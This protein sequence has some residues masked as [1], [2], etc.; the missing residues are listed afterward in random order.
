MKK[1]LAA[2]IAAALVAVALFCGCAP[3]D[4]R[5][6]R[7]GKDGQDVSIR[8]IYEEAKAIPGNEELTFE[9]FLKQY[10]SYDG[11]ALE[12]AASLKAAVNNSLMCGVTVLTRFPYSGKSSFVLPSARSYLVY[13]G[14]G[15]IID[16]DKE[17]G[18]AYVVTNCHVVYD[19]TSLTPYSEDIRLYLYGQDERDVNYIIDSSY[20]ISGDENYKISAE[21]AG[22]SRDYDLALLKISDSE[23]LKRSDARAAVFSDDVDAH[24]GETAYTIGNASGEGMSASDGIISKDSEYITLTMSNKENLLEDDYWDYRVLR[25]TAP[26]NHGNSGGAFYNTAGEIIG[27]VNSKYEGEDIDNMGYVLPVNNVRRIIEFMRENYEAQGYRGEGF[28]KAYLNIVTKITDSYARLDSQTGLAEIYETVR[29][30]EVAGAPSAGK[31]QRN[32]VL[33]AITLKSASGEVKDSL[34]VTRSYQISEMLFSARKG[35]MVSLTVERG[36]AETEVEIRLD[37]DSCFRHVN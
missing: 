9:E 27:I 24:I 23:V 22:V 10:L 16:L 29:I 31:L 15:V 20:N 14:S 37:S 13:T 1:F 19:D 11:S 6:G 32:D 35:D 26:I 17:A 36:G 21:L 5:D 2:A 3:A 30:A 25:T 7:D 28:D 18:D 8:Q 12:E 4:G 34:T 33:R